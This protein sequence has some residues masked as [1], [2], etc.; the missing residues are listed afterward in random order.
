MDHSSETHDI[1]Y[2]LMA[3]HMYKCK[4]CEF[5]SHATQMV[6][7]HMAAVH[8]KGAYRCGQCDYVGAFAS[9][10]K[11]HEKKHAS[12][13]CSKCDYKTAFKVEWKNHE[14]YK[15]GTK[16]THPCPECEYAATRADSLR[17]HINS[18]HLK[19]RYPC[20]LCNHTSTNKGDL[21]KHVKFKHN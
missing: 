18:V 12:F 19:I 1:E 4:L 6:K 17:I 14:K 16:N 11:N 8:K 7:N 5:V 10:L 13:A 3:N 9:S 2:V 21:S 15:H 20:D